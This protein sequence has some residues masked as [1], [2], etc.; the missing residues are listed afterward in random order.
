MNDR[1]CT[2]CKVS[3]PFD[4]FYKDK[5]RKDGL[6]SQCKNC[7]YES[8]KKYRELN[9]QKIKTSNCEYYVNNKNKEK[10]QKWYQSNKNKSIANNKKWRESNPEKVL[11]ANHLRRLRKL[12]NG[13]F[14]V[15]VKELNKL[16]NSSCFYCGSIKKIEMDHVV[17]LSRGGSHGIGNL[18][19]ACSKCNLSK[20]SKYLSE[21]RLS[22]KI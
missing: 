5:R 21:W 13:L 19:P 1:T 18:V 10:K 6:R 22:V 3:Q 11:N 7:G 8:N 14:L 15:T 16:Y 4:S 12:N 2:K 20:G 9:F 17:P